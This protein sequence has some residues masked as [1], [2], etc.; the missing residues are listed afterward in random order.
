MVLALE[1]GTLSTSA[2][3]LNDLYERYDGVFPAAAEY[4]FKLNEGLD[5]ILN[6][7]SSLRGTYLVKHLALS[8]LMHNKYGLPTVEDK[9]G[10]ARIGALTGPIGPAIDGLRA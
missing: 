6:H 7:F 5:F 1:R 10:L 8:A 4:A 9:T 3:L 2:K